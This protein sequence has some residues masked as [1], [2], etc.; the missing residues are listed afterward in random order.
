M[1]LRKQSNDTL[2]WTRNAKQIEFAHLLA[3]K[4]VSFNTIVLADRVKLIEIVGFTNMFSE[5]IIIYKKEMIV[6]EVKEY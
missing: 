3:Q 5:T 1:Q 2:I 4:V 6:Q